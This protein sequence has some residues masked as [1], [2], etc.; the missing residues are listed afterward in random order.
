MRGFKD[1]V[2]PLHYGRHIQRLLNASDTREL[3]GAGP[4]VVDFE[5]LNPELNAAFFKNLDHLHT[6]MEHGAALLERGVHVLVYAVSYDWVA[7]WVGNEC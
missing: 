4:A 1:A 3:I 6:V 2:L 7:I 5:L